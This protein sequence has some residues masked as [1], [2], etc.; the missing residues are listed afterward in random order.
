MSEIS[1]CTFISA[2]TGH[3]VNLGTISA[4]V[5][6]G[7]DSFHDGYTAASSGN[8]VIL[9]SVDSGITL[10]I[11][12]TGGNSPS[13]YNTGLGTVTVVSSA[14]LTI[15]GLEAGTEVRV[16][17]ASNLDLLDGIETVVTPDGLTYSDGR[18]RY[19]FD[20]NYSVVEDVFFQ[21]LNL[22][23]IFQKID[24]SLTADGGVLPVQQIIERNYI[25]P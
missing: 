22:N 15:T 24:F 11:N 19:K 16:H 25:N 5:A 3:G 13:V 17:R 6:M 1:N 10:T 2:G 12:V 14:T 23:Y 4:N 8:E 7:W 20:Y 21:I 9:V 18:I